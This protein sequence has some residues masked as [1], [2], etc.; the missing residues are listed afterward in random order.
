METS[1]V[2]FQNSTNRI[3][4]SLDI[5]LAMQ[6]LKD[7]MKDQI[8]VSGLAI[9]TFNP[10]LKMC[11]VV[12]SI[13]PPGFPDMTGSVPIPKQFWT[14][15][16]KDLAQGTELNLIN[17]GIQ[18]DAEQNQVLNQ[19]QKIL[20]AFDVP[21]QYSHMGMYLFIERKRFGFFLIFTDDETGY[22]KDHAK[23]LSL[24]REPISLTVSNSLHY[25]KIVYLNSVLKKENE[26]LSRKIKKTINDKI[27]GHSTGLRDVMQM[28]TQVAHL[29]S[30]VL[31]SGETGVGKEVLANAIHVMS[32]RKNQ[33]FIKVNC[34]AIPEFLI[35]SE[36]FGHEKGA[37]TG[38]DS[39][40]R[41]RF[42]RADKGTIFLDEIG[43]LPLQAQVK[44]L[45]VL[46]EQEFE[47]VGGTNVI[48]INIRIVSATNQNLEEMVRAGK[49]REDLWFRLN[50]CP[51][52]IPPLR[53]RLIDIPAFIK[54]FLDLKKR[55]FK[56]KQV[57]LISSKAMEILQSYHWPGN[58]RELGN[59]VERSLIRQQ[60]EGLNTPL[61]F[62]LPKA[63]KKGKDCSEVFRYEPRMSLD[64][65]IC[66][67]IL[68]T[69]E[70][71]GGKIAG[72]NGA[73]KLLDL[74]PSTLH[75]R[76]KKMGIVF[77]RNF[78]LNK[79]Q[80]NY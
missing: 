48:S 79:P 57:P 34:G 33:P 49:F 37:F 13:V 26:Y 78:E 7:Y 4:S 5:T 21:A 62:D 55:E 1:E 15:L 19:Y 20:E 52:N 11:D 27:I 71:T 32:Q 72:E 31:L 2:F 70:Q 35:E 69:L 45:R 47:R 8:P 42:E 30:P 9:A 16:K 14:F 23:L 61:K 68:Q 75:S 22:T 28:V 36:L 60:I 18:F 41:G 29:K 53:Q 25:E 56:L 73:A 44:L 77:S 80:N 54:H 46:Q 64:S 3:V 58:V 67:H 6:R 51:I 59:V 38:A 39:S 50:V 76:I 65:V 66:A 12:T 74:N 24:L 10:N 43:E 17:T 63:E 40:R